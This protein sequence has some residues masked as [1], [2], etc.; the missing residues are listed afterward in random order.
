MAVAKRSLYQVLLESGRRRWPAIVVD[1]KL[2]SPRDGELLRVER[3]EAYLDALNEAGVEALSTPTDP[4]HFGGSVEIA[5]RIRARCDIP[6]LRKEFFTSVA[7]MDESHDAG[8]DAV[9][10]SLGTIPDRELLRAMRRRAERLGLE[11]V[12]GAHGERQLC[13]AIGLGASAIGLNNR[14]I[15]ALELDSGTVTSTEALMP[16]V[17]P[18]VYVISE[19]GLLSTADVARAATAG[20]HAVMIG[21]AVARSDDPTALVQ[22]LRVDATCAR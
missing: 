3:L 13:E 17:P 8:F 19:S 11:V 22:A 21:T 14:D 16:L 2:R 7:Q 10:L 20:V 15:T 18:G 5:G 6:L 9:Q 12:I 1:V 4:V